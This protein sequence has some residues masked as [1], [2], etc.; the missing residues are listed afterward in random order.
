VWLCYVWGRKLEMNR[1]MILSCEEFEAGGY[2]LRGT[3]MGMCERVLRRG[4]ASTYK[5]KSQEATLFLVCSLFCFEGSASGKSAAAPLHLT[6][7]TVA[8]P[9]LLPLQS[10]RSSH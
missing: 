3:V 6:N 7:L 5:G 4:G 2:F 1:D 10:Q 8:K 9:V